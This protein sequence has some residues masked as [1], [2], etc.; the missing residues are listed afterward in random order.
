MGMPETPRIT[1]AEVRH[2]AKLARLALDDA[3]AKRLTEQLGSVLDYVAQL[4]D[5]DV[6]GVE[7]MNH[8]LDM[9]NVLRDDR[10]AP[11]MARD[12]ALANAPERDGAFF[13]VP[14]VLD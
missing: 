14:K 2:V 5:L 11:P 4:Q 6:E 8:P 9:P 7:P 3:D 10:V 1:E 12:T 13:K